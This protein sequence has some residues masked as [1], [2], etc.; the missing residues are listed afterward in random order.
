MAGAAYKNDH[1]VKS[2]VSL[3]TI[4]SS[5]EFKEELFEVNPHSSQS[6]HFSKVVP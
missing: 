5:K 2:V 4:S 3:E 1:P 6:C